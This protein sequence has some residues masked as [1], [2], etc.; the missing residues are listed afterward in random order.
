MRTFGIIVALGV[1]AAGGLYFTG[2]VD[3]KVNASVT[4][5]GKETINQGLARTKS[6]INQGLDALKVSETK[7]AK[8]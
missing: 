6:G 2:M 3:G 1:L 5:K 4:S 7:Q 8:K